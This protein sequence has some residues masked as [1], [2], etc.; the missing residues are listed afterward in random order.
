MAVAGK[1][2]ITLSTENGGAWSANVTYD[3]LV[4]VK[5][6]NNLYISRKVVTNV[7]PPNDEFWF[8]ALE[9]YSGEDVQELINRM[10]EFA[11]TL[12]AIITGAQQV[13]NAKTLD[14]HGAEY[15]LPKSGGTI[16]GDVTVNTDKDGNRIFTL[17]NGTK[18]IRFA[19]YAGGVFRIRN[20]TNN[21][22]I[23]LNTADGTNTFNGTAS[24]NLPLTGGD[25]TRA[26]NCIL[27]LLNTGTDN[28]TLMGFVQNGA[29]QGYIGFGGVDKPIVYSGNIGE[30]TILHT[31]NKPTGT[32]TGN[33]DATERIIATGGIGSALLVTGGGYSSIVTENGAFSLDGN[34]TIIGVSSG[35][36]RFKN[37]SY[38]IVT[39]SPRFNTSGTTYTWQVL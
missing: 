26:A 31:G 32:Y 12:E 11:N 18:N 14:G 21:K 2:A 22:D 34:S 28:K 8:L 17:S 20:M 38:S 39:T 13:G 16:D 9:G 33:G 5:H 10:N 7:E 4:A 29:K 27:R 24:G 25:L 19:V 6:N 1:V 36:V 35:N 3:R 15:F 30:Q 23:I 37:C